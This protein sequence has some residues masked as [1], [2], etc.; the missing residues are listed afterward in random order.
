MAFAPDA[1]PDDIAALKRLLLG[2]DELIAKL[3]AEIARLKRWQFGRSAERVEETIAQLQ[4]AL[5]DLQSAPKVMEEA[6]VALP[7]VEEST[8][9]CPTQRVLPFRRA[10]RSLPAHLPRE[11]VVHAPA[12]CTCPACGGALRK[13]GE[14]IAEMLDFVPGYFQ[15]I[16]HIAPSS[17]ARAVRG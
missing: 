17:P 9:A 6:P 8:Q 11:T 10:P 15:V 16:R 3:M 12:A 7:P 13:L 4:L 1:L 2:R 5:D 14:D